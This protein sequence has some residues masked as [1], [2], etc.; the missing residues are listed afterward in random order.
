MVAS[1]FDKKKH[2]TSKD[3]SDKFRNLVQSEDVQSFNM[4]LVNLQWTLS[5][6]ECLEYEIVIITVNSIS[7]RSESQKSEVFKS[8]PNDLQALGII[9]LQCSVQEI[10]PVVIQTLKSLIELLDSI[11]TLFNAQIADQTKSVTLH[12]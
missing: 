10:Q 6:I 8:T 3:S 2:H 1:K 9:K 5:K 4:Y 11:G 7:S 12:S